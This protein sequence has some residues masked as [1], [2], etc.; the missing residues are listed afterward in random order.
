MKFMISPSK[1]ARALL[2]I[3]LSLICANISG[4]YALYTFGKKY[5]HQCHLLSLIYQFDLGQGSNI[6]DWYESATL[7][8]CALLLAAIAFL[9]QRRGESFVIRWWLLALLFLGLSVDE[10]TEAHQVL[11]HLLQAALDASGLNNFTWEIPVAVCALLLAL[12][13]VRFL[14][15]LPRKTCVVFL[16]AGVIYVSGAL[17][18][19]MVGGWYLAENGQPDFT[20]AL[21]S[22]AEE[23]FEMLGVVIFVYSL[24]DYLSLHVKDVRLS[25]GEEAPQPI[26]A[27]QPHPI[28]AQPSS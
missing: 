16:V 4:Q 2:L 24:T 15:A 13:Y 12:V 26:T 21:I 19:E 20:L 9:K 7:L 8:L 23:F 14:A 6:P 25:I 11:V 22:T 5:L 17:G 3:T 28:G 18:L 1:V 27:L 10:A